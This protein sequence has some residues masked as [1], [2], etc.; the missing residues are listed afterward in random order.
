VKGDNYSG[1]LGL[2]H[3]R[4]QG[5]YTLSFT[6]VASFTALEDRAFLL[7]KEGKLYACGSNAYGMLGLKDCTQFNEWTRFTLT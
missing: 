5:E 4:I 6:G 3:Y 7:T 1:E 2:G